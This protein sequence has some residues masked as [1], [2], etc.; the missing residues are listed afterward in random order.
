MDTM[1]M[2][3]LARVEARAASLLEEHGLSGWT[4]GWDRAVKRRGQT[5]YTA[6]RITLSRPIAELASFEESE[7]TLLHEV[8]HALIGPGH[9]HDRAWL[10]KARSIGFEGGR[11]S[12]RAVE[13]PL[14]W[15]G[16]C[17]NGHTSQRAR[18]PQGISS[19]GRCSK[20]FDLRYI[21]VFIRRA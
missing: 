1:T 18:R 2:T 20:R 5:N 10:A 19:C 13:V 8:G 7:Q 17:P 14:A 16:T 3:M 11:T 12:T 6:K 4:F 21:I 15:V 9:G